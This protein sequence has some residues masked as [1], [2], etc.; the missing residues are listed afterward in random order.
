MILRCL[1]RS[2]VEERVGDH[3]CHVLECC[4]AGA[5]S[6]KSKT[7]TPLLSIWNE[8]NGMKISKIFAN[9]EVGYFQ[10]KFGWEKRSCIVSLQRNSFAL[11]S[12]VTRIEAYLIHNRTQRNVSN[13]G[14]FLSNLTREKSRRTRQKIQPRIGISFNHLRIGDERTG[15]YFDHGEGMIASSLL[16]N[17]RSLSIE[18]SRH[19]DMGHRSMPISQ[20]ANVVDLVRTGKKMHR[21]RLCTSFLSKKSFSFV[22]WFVSIIIYRHPVRQNIDEQFCLFSKIHFWSAN[23]SKLSESFSMTITGR[24]PLQAT[25]MWFS[26]AIVALSQNFAHILHIFHRTYE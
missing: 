14:H 1:L 11:L 24:K 17:L 23:S 21:S 13:A 22:D 9:N 19:G 8:M 25:N 6:A 16:L 3:K 2:W 5:S 12:D 20:I 10:Q 26:W 18:I 15:E 4:I 7:A